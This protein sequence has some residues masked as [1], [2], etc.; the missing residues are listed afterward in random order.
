MTSR[1]IAEL[2]EYFDINELH[3]SFTNG[4]WRYQSWGYPVIDAGPGAEVWAWFQNDTVQLIDEKW[5]NL[6]GT[7]SGLFCASLSFIDESN[8]FE[9]AYSLRP[10][11][12]D[13]DNSVSKPIVRFAAL[14]REIVCTENLTPWKKL[15]PC[16][17]KEGFISILNPDHIYST[18]YHSLG[19]HMRKLCMTKE[20]SKYQIEVKQ[21]VNL[22]HDLALF[23]GKDW[24]IRKLFGSGLFGACTLSGMT[25]FCRKKVLQFC[26]TQ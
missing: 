6:C 11:F 18:N 4:L 10:L 26:T 12:H 7:L 14:P 20:C 16:S 15:L 19:V 5:K 23:G 25:Y 1:S 17:L 22:V 13:N 3:I 24:S 8:T 9:P 2:F 21:T